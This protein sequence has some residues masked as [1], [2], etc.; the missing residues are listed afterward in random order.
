MTVRRAHWLTVLKIQ[1]TRGMGYQQW[2]QVIEDHLP[3]H[4]WRRT[5]AM[6]TGVV[7]ERRTT[8]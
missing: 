6:R 4:D 8:L 5:R 1:P 3:V 7:V 2:L